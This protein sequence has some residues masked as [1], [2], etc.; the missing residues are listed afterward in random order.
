MSKLVLNNINSGYAST[1]ALNDNFALIETALENTLSRDGTTPN[2]MENNLDMNSNRIINLGQAVSN[3]DALSYGQFLE[4]VQAE[5]NLTGI[6]PITWEFISTG[7]ASYTL[8]LASSNAIDMYIVSVNGLIVS[9]SDYVISTSP[10]SISFLSTPPAIGAKIVVRLFGKIPEVTPDSIKISG[11]RASTVF[12]IVGAEQLFATSFNL[13][14]SSTDVYLNGV[15]LVYGLDYVV[16]GTDVVYIT[17]PATAGD[18][19]EVV[20]HSVILA[21]SEDILAVKQAALDAEAAAALAAQ[22]VFDAAAAGAAAGAIAGAV[23]INWLT[24]TANYTAATLDGIFADTSAGSFTVTL[25]ATPSVGNQVYFMDITSSFGLNALTIARN[26]EYIMGLD[27][28]MLVNTPNASFRLI[29]TGA[30]NGWRIG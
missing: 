15:K 2:Q 22:S 3:S 11:I 23:G 8:P 18:T 26:S 10:Q 25:P 4:I 13:T 27:E 14:S 17:S 30:A 1:S 7:V 20:S 12:T 28:D 16:V 6:I 5:Q 24:K 29:Y 19:L 9:P 21:A